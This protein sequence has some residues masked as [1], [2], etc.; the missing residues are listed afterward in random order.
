M[1]IS[2]PVSGTHEEKVAEV[3]GFLESDDNATFVQGYSLVFTDA[4]AAF[5]ASIAPVGY[6]ITV[7][8]LEGNNYKITAREDGA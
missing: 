5:V 4:I 8:Y 1:P 2:I 6:T 3:V 7:E